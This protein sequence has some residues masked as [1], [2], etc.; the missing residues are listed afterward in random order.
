MSASSIS[1]DEWSVRYSMIHCQ[2]V[3][4]NISDRYVQLSYMQQLDVSGPSGCLL[5]CLQR[6]AWPTS[7]WQLVSVGSVNTDWYSIG[8]CKRGW[9]LSEPCVD[10]GVYGVHGHQGVRDHG[11]TYQ[12]NRE[13]VWCVHVICAVVH[14]SSSLKRY[15]IGVVWCSKCVFTHT[16]MLCLCVGLQRSCSVF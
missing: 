12:L 1:L 13:C 5:G 3:C 9:P 14:R 6:L 2:V 11:Q 16:G 15:S 4:Y 8:W 7:V 10:T